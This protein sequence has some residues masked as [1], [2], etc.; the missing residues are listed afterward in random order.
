MPLSTEPQT[1][2]TLLAVVGVEKANRVVCQAPGCGHGVYRR[3]HVVRHDNSTL[4]V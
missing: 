2:G 4:G 1:S 3:I